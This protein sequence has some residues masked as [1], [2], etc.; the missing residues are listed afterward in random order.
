MWLQSPSLSHFCLCWFLLCSA[1]STRPGMKALSTFPG[2][3]LVVGP[4]PAP[5][6]YAGGTR[7][8]GSLLEWLAD[9]LEALLVI[10]LWR[11]SRHRGIQ[12]VCTVYKKPSGAPSGDCSH[13]FTLFPCKMLL[14]VLHQGQFILNGM[15]RHS[16]H[17]YFLPTLLPPYP[18][19]L[20]LYMVLREEAIFY[21]RGKKE[22]TPLKRNL[23][24]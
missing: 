20:K 15:Y 10:S 7:S 6:R 17:L 2:S 22:L 12:A 24:S 4:A 3:S 18:L 5:G 11:G 9:W 1:P 19:L 14:T 13:L 8:D 16:I 21:L 23:Q